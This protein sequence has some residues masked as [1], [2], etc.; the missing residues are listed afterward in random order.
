MS[1]SFEEIANRIMFI[2]TPP[3][4]EAH[5][6]DD[7]NLVTKEESAKRI[8]TLFLIVAIILFTIS[9]VALIVISNK[10]MDNSSIRMHIFVY[11]DIPYEVF[12]FT[13]HFRGL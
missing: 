4:R 3:S 1:K 8:T 10:A 7:S 5:I 12:T 2:F 11:F 6:D 9:L 13:L